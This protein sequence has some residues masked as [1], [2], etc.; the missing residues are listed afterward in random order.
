ML[1]WLKMSQTEFCFEKC[2]KQDLQYYDIVL[3]LLLSIVSLIYW[4]FTG[5][6][7]MILCVWKETHD[8]SA[9]NGMLID[10]KWLYCSRMHMLNSYI[11]PIATAQWKHN[12]NSKHSG[13]AIQTM[14][15]T[16]PSAR[17][18]DIH[19]SSILIY[20]SYMQVWQVKKTSNKIVNDRMLLW[21]HACFLHCFSFTSNDIMHVFCTVLV[22]L[23]MTVRHHA[24]FTYW[25]VWSI[26]MWPCMHKPTLCRI[27]SFLR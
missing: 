3:V 9:R 26:Y 13:Q 11:V 12:E 8:R 2:Q 27:L 25:S 15:V 4:P 6:T 21:L 5:Y 1:L 16:V 23:L 24:S 20:T 18:T 19:I 22:S 10:M 14:G 7:C 17:S